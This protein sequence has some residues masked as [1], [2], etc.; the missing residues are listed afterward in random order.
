MNEITIRDLKCIITAPEGIN[1]VV[2][3]LDTSEP[4]LTGY[5]CAT[6][7]YRP[8]AVQLVAETY[9]KPLLT[10]RSVR[11]IGD[12]WQLMYQNAY[13]RNDVISANAISGIDM[14]LWDIKGKIAEMP[15]HDLLGG[16]RRPAA[17]VY[18]HA[19]GTDPEAVLESVLALRAEGMSHTRV[20]FGIYG[21]IEAGAARPRGASP[22]EYYDPAAYR[23]Q[24]LAMLEHLKK[25]LPE[26][27]ELLHDVHERLSP[28]DAVRFATELQEFQLFFLEDL[29][30]PEQSEYFQ[31]VRSQCSVPLACGELFTHPLEWDGLI[32][33]RLID[34]IRVHISMIGGITPAL[35]LAAF[36]AASGVRTAWHGPGDLSPIGHAVNV[37]LDLIVENFGIQEWIGISDRLREVFPGSPE[38]VEGFAYAP[39][40]HGIGVAIDEKAAAKFPPNESVTSWTQTRLPDGGLNLP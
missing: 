29:L 35:K 10:G 25:H 33:R 31:A 3:R 12:L 14:A 2:I 32:R 18:R 20:Q 37:H 27:Q 4:G 6:L 8:L 7:A 5:G 11:D 40:G 26:D 34:F 36:A 13:W 17:R 24:T 9:L 38:L 1:L 30:P 16:R 39:S 15:L 23:R 19:G 22:G 28:A 21:G